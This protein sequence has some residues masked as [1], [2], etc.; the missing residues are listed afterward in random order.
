MP[1]DNMKGRTSRRVPRE[2]RT[3]KVMVQMYCAANHG[4]GDR[5]L[6]TG[7]KDILR[8][9]CG[10][11]LAYSEQRIERCSFG[12]AKPTCARCPVHCFRSDMRDQ[13]RKVMRYSGPRMI[14]RHPYLAIRHA[15][16][17]R[18]A[19]DQGARPASHP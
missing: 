9:R 13:I 2:R 19:L 5:S 11:L 16:D 1:P 14:L 15:L 3:L 8:E 7:R 17:G 4:G 10:L 12:H 18:R 6:A